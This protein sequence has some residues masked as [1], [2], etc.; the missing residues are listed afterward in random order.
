M[1]TP[2]IGRIG[3]RRD[4]QFA[5]LLDGTAAAAAA[6]PPG[7]ASMAGLAGALRAA[8]SAYPTAPDPDFRAALRQRLVAVATVQGADPVVS[9]IAV[10]SR[11][12]LVIGVRA[13]RGL[14]ALVG[15]AAIATSVTG[16]AVAASRSL[17]GDP[18]Y[19][20]KKSTEAVQLWT[21]RGDVAKGKRHLEFARTRLAEAQA[22][23]PTSSHLTSTLSAMNSQTVQGSRELIR[24]AKSSGSTAP[25]AALATFSQ[26]QYTGLNQLASTLPPAAR[27]PEAA[28][29][30]LLT[31]VV[32]QV[33]NI[34]HGRCVLCAETRGTPLT[35]SSPAPSARTPSAARTPGAVRTPARHHPTTGG[36]LPQLSATARGSAPTP[37]RGGS[38]PKPTPTHSKLLPLPTVT[39]PPNPVTSILNP[40][41]TKKPKPIL[42]PL[43]G[44]SS[45]LGGIGL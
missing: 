33:R 40:H 13:R 38:T 7:M 15:S 29:V 26:Q 19:G 4:E 14:A 9:G 5:R 6:V 41:P 25:L 36:I 2:R 45:L 37:S 10:P 18:F 23:P 28:A 31:T 27:A 30:T 24:A 32:K 35:S 8:G 16:V 34:A 20:V 22:L 17:P 42:T 43:P 39:L 12:R 11:G 3:A 44:L 21:A 1:S